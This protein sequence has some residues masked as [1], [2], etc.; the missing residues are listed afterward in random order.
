MSQDTI[1]LKYENE[2]GDEVEITLPSKL[3]VCPECQG[4][5]FVLRDGLRG[6]SFTASEFEECFEEPE[7][8]EEYFRYGGKY[9]QQCPTCHGNNVVPA[10]N[11]EYLSEAEKK[12][13]AEYKEWE[14]DNARYEAEAADERAAE[15]RMGC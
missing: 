2:D 6:E 14:E 7:D 13:Y 10:V 3:G 12:L 1:K 11:E 15:R 5:G 8:R 9:D 4:H